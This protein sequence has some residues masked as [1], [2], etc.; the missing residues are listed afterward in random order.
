MLVW[1]LLG[2][3][4]LAGLALVLHRWDSRHERGLLAFYL[5]SLAVLDVWR[6][7][8]FFLTD[9]FVQGAPGLTLAGLLVTPRL[10]S[11]VILLGLLAVFL[12]RGT[13]PATRLIIQIFALGIV[14]GVVVPF[15]LGVLGILGW[16]ALPGPAI[17]LLLSGSGPRLAETLA[18]VAGVYVAIVSYQSLI[19]R[20]RRLPEFL[21]GVAALLA[22]SVVQ[23]LLFGLGTWPGA[24]EAVRRLGGE[25]AGAVLSVA[26]VLP[27]AIPCLRRVVPDGLRRDP[28]VVRR[29][30][31]AVLREMLSLRRA[32]MESRQAISQLSDT[33]RL[34]N[35]ARHRIVQATHPDRLMHEMCELLVRSRR[36]CFAWIGMKRQGD[37]VVFPA[38]QAGEGLDYLKVVTITW[39]ESP[40]GQ[41]PMGVAIRENRALVI[42][43]ART[44]ERFRPWSDEALR[45]G[46][47]SVAGLP[48]RAA[49]QTVGGL[50][51]YAAT[52]HAFSADE[53]DLLQ[54]VADDLAHGLDRLRAEQL[55][56]RQL[57]QLD[58]L[59][60]MTQ[61]LI[62]LREMPRLLERMVERGVELLD[63][64]SGGLYL[65]DRSRGRLRAVVG[66]RLPLDIV[67]VELAYGEGAAGMAAQSGRGLIVPDYRAWP[68]RSSAY[69]PEAPFRAVLAAPMMWQGEAVGV[70]DVLRD[71][72]MTP[73]SQGDLDLLQLFAN[74]A[75]LA[76]ENAR[77]IEGAETRIRQ[78]NLLHELTVSAIGAA[79]PSDFIEVLTQRMPELLSADSCMLTF[80]DQPQAAPRN[81]GARGSLLEAVPRL[82]PEAG[83]RTLTES[84]LR[85]GKVLAIESVGTCELLSGRQ[86]AAFPTPSLLVAPLIV[87]ERWLGAVFL[88]FDRP[89]AFRPEEVALAEQAGALA[90]LALAKLEAIEAEQGRSATLTALR[91]ASLVVT[92]RLELN[93]VLQSVLEHALGLIRGDDGHIFLYD[94]QA[95]TFGAARWAD[96]D[97]HE[98]FAAPRPDG[99]TMHVARTGTPAVIPSV[100]DHPLFADWKWG[101]A[102][103]GMPL[104]VGA[105]V[106]GVMNLAF[107]QPRSFDASE[108]DDLRL[109]ADQAALAIQ[110]ASL[111]AKADA[112]RQR[113]RLL[114]DVGRRL[115]AGAE[116]EVLLQTAVD[117]TTHSLD[118]RSGDAFLLEADGRRLRLVATCRQDGLALGELAARLDFNL[119]RGLE[120]WVAAQRTACLV[121]DVTQDTRWLRVS[122]VDDPGGSAICAPLL[123]EDRLLG[124]M[125]I[126]GD[127]PY[128]P[129]HLEL[130]EAISRQVALALS[131]AGRYT[132][133]ERR[134]REQEAVQQ[135][136][137]VIGRRLEMQPLLEEVCQQVAD[138]LG[139]PNVEI[140]LVEGEDLS[141]QAAK[142]DE[143]AVGARIPLKRGIVGRVARSDK[144]AYVPDV[145][146]DADYVEAIST[147][148]SEIVVP[149]HKGN[150][151]IGVLNVESPVL[152]GLTEDDARLLTLVGDQV[153]VAIENAALYDRLRRH[154]SEL[155]QTV[156]E[157]TARLAEA[158]E[159]AT[160]ADRLKTQFV[161]DVSHELR[162]PLTNIR[163][164]L[165]LISQASRER[166]PEYLETLNR[167]TERLV[168]LIEDLLAI[169]RL[170]VGTHPPELGLLDV[171]AL[172]RGLVADRRRMFDERRLHVTFDPAPEVP[173]VLADGRM[174]SQ[175]LANL[176]TN[177]MHYTLPGGRVELATQ[178]VDL[179]GQRWATLRVTDTGLGIPEEEQA[180]VFERFYRGTASRRM[181]APGTGLGLSICKEILDRH[182]GH[183]Q[184]ESRVGEGTT[185]TLWLPAG[186]TEDPQAARGARSG[187][188]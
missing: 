144:M 140:L 83:E 133:V 162:T 182:G 36:Y 138:V 51:V 12:A 91:Q 64:R 109:M 128:R 14:W 56:T 57:R 141:L 41:G 167:E 98:P 124:V 93:A 166:F 106:L 112:E 27:L 125:T 160:E 153:S 8:L 136:A 90:A 113:L 53:I 187:D 24:G 10:V 30:A 63:G 47:L 165:E 49:G 61:D 139:Y 107:Q 80:W 105:Q 15:V 96:S 74:Q 29:P 52:P 181:G 169:S 13:A 89:R 78:L 177:A 31:V 37:Q 73:F 48:M 65:C 44:D 186:P 4:A 43:D 183:I 39:D 79:G 5:Q 159:R 123:V 127:A 62:S 143:Y 25:T 87:G 135:V 129:E 154:S 168:D 54:G 147:T 85:A 108:V 178:G 171:N 119:E 42:G 6:G 11:P 131:N 116:S 164:Y 176:M 122:G 58:I 185:F 101:G 157:R 151:V 77:L 95:L 179:D 174:L 120:G 117:L 142:G 71:E 68:Q 94:G 126:V 16:V 149:L 59:R 180:H 111:F 145:R 156:A 72:G 118:G 82:R 148:R 3:W 9:G 132:Q 137:Q 40:T 55:N 22:G 110:N 19:N 97:R 170:D 7:T 69:P 35:E 104:C 21:V 134:L 34:L 152:H 150:L 146:L 99:V 81:V 67:G 161:A 23:A 114:T 115:A 1:L 172:A 102:I 66:Y 103:I 17:D 100:D 88:G 76:L 173:R 84:A 2:S 184:L 32:L 92:S 26:A 18:L 28:A 130:L 60:G 38:A 75:A 86:A 155:E 45:R 158:L 188:S 33:L 20:S 70:I 46:Y 50:A 163:L 121:E 175:V